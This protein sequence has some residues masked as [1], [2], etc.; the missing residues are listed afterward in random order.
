MTRLPK[1]ENPAVYDSMVSGAPMSVCPERSTKI[2]PSA[3]AAEV[4]HIAA[5]ANESGLSQDSLAVSIEPIGKDHERPMPSGTPREVAIS[6]Q[7][8]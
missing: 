7:S 2:N 6:I 3:I 5:S 4:G 1:F 8:C